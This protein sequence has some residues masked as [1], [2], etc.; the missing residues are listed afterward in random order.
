MSLWQR[1]KKV[2][3]NNKLMI[4]MTAI[5]AVA[6][7]LYTCMYRSQVKFLEQ[8]AEQQAA[9]TEKLI[10]ASERMANTANRQAEDSRKSNDE[11]LSKAERLTRANED[12]VKAATKQASTSQVSARAAESSAKFAEK[13]V[14]ATKEAT[15]TANRAYLTIREIHPPQLSSDKPLMIYVDWDNDGNSP[16][17]TIKG[18]AAVSITTALPTLTE[19]LHH[20]IGPVETLVVQPHST[21]TQR[22][23][24]A[25]RSFSQPQID[26]VENGQRILS[27]CGNL[28]YETLGQTFSLLFCAHWDKDIKTYINCKEGGEK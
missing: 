8:S 20:A 22:F 28:S 18:I 27:I 16:A 15:F 5:L 19:C 10:A 12:L 4:Y 25:A 9:Q 3:I 13:T 21:R 6:T 24:F 26:A 2:S 23:I 1:W 14:E 11:M 7:T 17:R